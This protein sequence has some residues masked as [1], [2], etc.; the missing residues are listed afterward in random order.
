MNCNIQLIKSRENLKIQWNHHKKALN[1][2]IYQSW[3]LCAFMNNAWQNSYSRKDWISWMA[4]P[5][6]PRDLSFAL[7]FSNFYSNSVQE[8]DAKQHPC[9]LNIRF[10]LKSSMQTVFFYNLTSDLQILCE[11]AS[12]WGNFLWSHFLGEKMLLEAERCRDKSL[13]ALRLPLL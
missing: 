3:C 11:A 6:K 10:S 12:D 7:T 8:S 1:L 2:A 5:D 9:Q 4:W 13:D